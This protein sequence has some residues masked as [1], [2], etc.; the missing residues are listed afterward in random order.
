M[1]GPVAPHEPL[2]VQL[3]NLNTQTL[4]QHTC[5]Q[6]ACSHPSLH[7][8]DGLV[9]PR[10]PLEVQL[11]NLNTQTLTQHTYTLTQHTYMHTRACSH[12]SLHG[13]DGLVAPREPL[14]VQ[15]ENLELWHAS[16]LAGLRTFKA[17]FKTAS[18][19]LMAMADQNVSRVGVCRIEVVWARK[20]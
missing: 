7:G 14:E 4:T 15:L 9:A 20:C 2:E 19:T 16:M 3:E 11:E 5:I 10:E 18:C 6:R 12:P 1:D 17:R 8:V 13:V